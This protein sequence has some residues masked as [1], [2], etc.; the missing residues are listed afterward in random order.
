VDITTGD[1]IPGDNASLEDP[2]R[3]I[4]KYLSALELDYSDSLSA[5]LSDKRIINRLYELDGLVTGVSQAREVV[6]EIAQARQE[7]I[8]DKVR[9]LKVPASDSRQD[10]GNDFR[11]EV[12]RAIQ[13]R[14]GLYDPNNPNEVTDQ[15]N[16]QSDLR[17]A[18]IE[19]LQFQLGR[20]TPSSATQNSP[21]PRTGIS[22]TQP[23]VDKYTQGVNRAISSGEASVRELSNQNLSGSNTDKD[24]TK[25]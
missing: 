1:T 24:K 7:I 10:G 17:V 13:E 2:Q 8:A 4:R 21:A 22:S 20:D 9:S 15:F 12:L 23:I 6:Q 11:Y 25:Y 18:L 3:L 19:N 14:F 16:P 5:E